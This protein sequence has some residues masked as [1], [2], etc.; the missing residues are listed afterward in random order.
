MNIQGQMLPLL[1]AHITPTPNP[2]TTLN[3]NEDVDVAC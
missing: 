2:E 1:P 3:R